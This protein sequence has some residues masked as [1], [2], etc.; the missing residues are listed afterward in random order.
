MAELFLDQA[1]LFASSLSASRS[2]SRAIS[3]PVSQTEAN[4][5]VIPPVLP[6]NEKQLYKP[7]DE[8]Y[9]WKEL[10]IEWTEIIG[11]YNDGDKLYYYVRQG[12]F[13]AHKVCALFSVTR[14]C[15]FDAFSF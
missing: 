5:Y 15:L 3:L 9:L 1:D 13:L 6:K 14:F 4:F 2:E 11:E 8:A 12:D 10:E 7:F